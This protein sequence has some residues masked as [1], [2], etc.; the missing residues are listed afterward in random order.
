MVNK[1][2]QG[3]GKG[4]AR[5]FR[6][7]GAGSRIEASVQRE[8]I[9]RKQSG[10]RKGRN[11]GETSEERVAFPDG[12]AL[13]CGNCGGVDRDCSGAPE[14]TWILVPARCIF[15]Q[16]DT[17]GEHFYACRAGISFAAD[18]ADC[19]Q[20]SFL[21]HSGGESGVR[22]GVAGQSGQSLSSVAGDFPASRFTIEGALSKGIATV[23]TTDM[24]GATRS[25]AATIGG[26]GAC[27]T[28][29]V[30]LPRIIPSS[31][32]NRLYITRV[33][34]HQ[35][36][37]LLLYSEGIASPR[38]QIRLPTPGR[39]VAGLHLERN[40]IAA[41]ELRFTRSGNWKTAGK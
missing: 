25:C 10:R 20:L 35:I 34:F 31:T 18:W 24:L 22:A 11:E 41:S 39:I 13:R 23:R 37:A 7:H 8:G 32:M 14:V 3:H 15:V 38:L 27:A 4:V 33:F 36:L 28:A 21:V 30:W 2:T 9:E 19:G 1:F 17:C 16:R 5:G 26:R 12:A 6:R 29:S 40:V